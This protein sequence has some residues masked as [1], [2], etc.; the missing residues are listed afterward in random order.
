MLL[1]FKM[2]SASVGH[3]PLVQWRIRRGIV[4]WP[5]WQ[6]NTNICGFCVS[7]F[8][9]SWQIRRFHRTSKS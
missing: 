6:D 8:Q 9:K 4:Q 2:A 1:V 3:R 5:H 7:K